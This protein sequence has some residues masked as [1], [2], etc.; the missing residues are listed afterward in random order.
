MTGAP[1]TAILGTK[2]T[3]SNAS[4]FAIDRAGRLATRPYEGDGFAV[5]STS[6]R[7]GGIYQD[8]SLRVAAGESF[9]ADAEVITAAKRSG[10]SGNMTLWLLGESSNQSSTI[11]F[12]PLPGRAPPL[13][14]V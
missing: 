8:I 7:G 14:I 2:P 3:D 1:G 10:A 4:R 9:C 13:L 6:A 12:G 5:T 11:G